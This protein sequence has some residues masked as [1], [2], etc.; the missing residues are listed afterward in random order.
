MAA[1]SSVL[2]WRIPGTA[3][4]GGLP[5]MGSHRVGHDW[6]DLAAAAAGSM[7]K[8]PPTNAAD[9]AL[10]P[11]WGRSPGEGHGNPLQYS[12]LGKS[13]DRG[14]WWATVHGLQRVGHDLA[15]KQQQSTN[16]LIKCPSAWICL[17]RWDRIF[18]ARSLLKWCYDLYPCL[19]I[20]SEG[21]WVQFVPLM[22]S[23]LIT[24][25]RCWMIEL[26]T[27]NVFSHSSW[28]NILWG[29]TLGLFKCPVSHL[30][31]AH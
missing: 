31:F 22:I 11:G 13:M 9:V 3:E 19:C 20:I 5:S 2:A 10:I 29:D 16:Y 7:V 24:W 1:H 8:N 17:I 15:T 4:P 26:S 14:A 23:I 21:A 28:T 12:C 6:S 25:L 18:L 30:T 27:V